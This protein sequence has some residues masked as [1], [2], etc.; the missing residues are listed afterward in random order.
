MPGFSL[1]PAV[2][3]ADIVL[4]I[5]RSLEKYACDKLR[6]AMSEFAAVSAALIMMDPQTGAIRAMCSFP[7]FD[8]N[9]YNKVEDVNVYN[10]T[11]IFYS[12][13]TRLNFQADHD[14]RRAK[15]WHFVSQR[16]ICGYW[17]SSRTLRKPIKNAGEKSYGIQTMTGILQKFH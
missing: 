4:T 2:P 10:N 17:R 1:N 16:S 15:C 11:A 6:R 3:G 5:D 12:L 7:D 8:P 13:R 14:G 9:T